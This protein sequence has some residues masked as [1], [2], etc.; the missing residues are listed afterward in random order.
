[1][2]IAAR[3][4]KVLDNNRIDIFHAQCKASVILLENGQLQ[5]VEQVL[6]SALS[7][8]ILEACNTHVQ[9]EIAKMKNI[10][11]E[12]LFRNAMQD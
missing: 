9:R 8:V 10:Q 5:V 7:N 2:R 3:K 6:E 4:K 12:L 1:M 11:Q